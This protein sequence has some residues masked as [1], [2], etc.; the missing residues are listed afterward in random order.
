M[1]LI[2]SSRCAAGRRGRRDARAPTAGRRPATVQ[3]KTAG[4][5]PCTSRQRHVR[6]GFRTYRGCPSV[7]GGLLP[8][9]FASIPLS[10]PAHTPLPPRAVPA[11]RGRRRGSGPVHNTVTRELR[12]GTRLWGVPMR[13]RGAGRP[14]AGQREKGVGA[15]GERRGPA[16]GGAAPSRRRVAP[17]ALRNGVTKRGARRRAPPTPASWAGRDSPR[18]GHPHS[19]TP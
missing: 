15:G 10:S 19:S 6:A 18:A 4:P 1:R 8:L 12:R 17:C 16:G 3:R 7:C 5:G 11:P 9:P 2:T 14:V 13:E